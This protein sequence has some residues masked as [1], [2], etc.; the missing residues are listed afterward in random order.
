MSAAPK[1]LMEMKGDLQAKTLSVPLKWRNNQ[2]PC[3]KAAYTTPP[4]PT[5]QS[6][7]LFLSRSLFPSMHKIVP[8]SNV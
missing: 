8:T 7:S 3:F 1:F 6:V 4:T 5:P 2:K